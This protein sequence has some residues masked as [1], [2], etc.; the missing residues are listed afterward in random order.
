MTFGSSLEI[1]SIVTDTDM[2]SLS[3]SDNCSDEDVD[4][5]ENELCLI[6]PEIE[7]T[8]KEDDFVLVKFE[9]ITQ[10]ASSSRAAAPIYYQATSWWFMERNMK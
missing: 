10:D 3:F 7:A 5:M 1:N 8:P 4:S 9:S 6:L 2:H